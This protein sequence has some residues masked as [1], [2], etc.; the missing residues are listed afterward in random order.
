M[1]ATGLTKFTITH[2]EYTANRLPMASTWYGSPTQ[3][4]PLRTLTQMSYLPTF[5]EFPGLSQTDLLSCCPGN[6]QNCPG[7][8]TRGLGVYYVQ[9]SLSDKLLPADECQYQWVRTVRTGVQEGHASGILIGS[10][11]MCPQAE[12]EPLSSV[13]NSLQTTLGMLLCS[14]SKLSCT[15]QQNPAKFSC[16]YKT[17]GWE[18]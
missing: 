12:R 16:V 8:Y 18:V 6:N 7:N 14:G 11:I 3:P 2:L 13:V 17:Q 1:G 5:P 9:A 10:A 4:R 15:R